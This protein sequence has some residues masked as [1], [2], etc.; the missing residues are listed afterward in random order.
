MLK[1]QV[2]IAISGIDYRHT[3]HIARATDN[4]IITTQSTELGIPTRTY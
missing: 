3:V 4:Q 1:I 2:L